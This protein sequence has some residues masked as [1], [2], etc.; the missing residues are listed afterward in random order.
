MLETSLGVLLAS[1]NRLMSLNAIDLIIIV[2]YFVLVLG[3][4]VYL[5]K[6][7]S[8]GN[9]F[10]MAGREMTAWIAG[11]SFIS[12]NLGSLEMMGYAAAT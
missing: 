9:D 4:G 12:A 5:R 3:L 2:L 11:L 8:T 10:F 1:D 6:F 7:A